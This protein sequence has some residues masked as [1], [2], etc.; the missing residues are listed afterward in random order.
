M[1][2]LPRTTLGR[3]ALGLLLPVLLYPAYW[4]VFPLLGL[5]NWAS[6]AVVVVIATL[7][8]GSLVIA[9][10]AILARRDRSPLLLVA[11]IATTALVAFFAVGEAV[12]H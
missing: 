4:W 11:A 7:A 10:F 12:G 9:W 2:L 1:D 8:L 5:P 6:V 3:V